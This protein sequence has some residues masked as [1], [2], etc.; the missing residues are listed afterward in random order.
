MD[1]YFMAKLNFY[2]TDALYK[3]EDSKAVIYLYG[4]CEQGSVLIKYSGFKPYFYVVP[5]NGKEKLLL[6]RLEGFSIT[7]EKRKINITKV[8]LK[9][10]IDGAKKTI[11]I[12][13]QTSIPKDVPHL[14][15]AIRELNN[16]SKVTEADIRFVNRFLVNHRIAIFEKCTAIGEFKGQVFLAKSITPGSEKYTDPRILAI[17]IETPSKEIN[18]EKYPIFMISLYGD[19]F[20]KV[21]TWKQQ[22]FN[23]KYVEVCTSEQKMLERFG[24]LVQEYNPDIICGYFS[25]EF[26]FPYIKRRADHLKVELKPGF[27]NSPILISRGKKRISSI[28]GMIHVDVFK[29]I[30]YVWGQGLNTSWFDLNSVA[31]EILGEGKIEVDIGQL[32]DSWE[33]NK[34]LD[35]FAEYNLKDSEL[36]YRL[37][38][39][40]IV[41]IIELC[42]LTHLTANQISRSRFSALVEGFLITKAYEDNVLVPKAPGHKKILERRAKKYQGAFVYEP[43]PGLYAN[44]AVFDFKS[45]YATL[46]SAFNI[47]PETLD[48]ECCPENKVPGL[49][50]WFCKNIRGFISEAEKEIVQR[51]MRLKE[52]ISKEGATKVLKARSHALKTLGNAMYGYIGFYASRWY[53][54]EA[55]EA[56]TAYGRDYLNQVIEKA[57][58]EGFEVVYGDTDS[59]FLKLPTKDTKKAKA[60]ARK[61]NESLPD[62]MELEFESFFP[63]GIFVSMKSSDVGAK[64]RYAMINEKGEITIKGFETVRRNISL[65]AREAQR[66][67]LELI[68]NEGDAK[69]ALEFIHKLVDQVK[70]NDI[71]KS[72]MIIKTQIKKA[73]SDYESVSPHVAVAKKLI[74]RGEKVNIGDR[75]EYVVLNGS[76]NVGDRAEPAQFVDNPDYDTDYY[77]N[78]QLIPAV[79]SIFQV[80]GMN[81][82]INS[83]DQSSLKTFF[84]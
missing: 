16:V 34:S 60:F 68:L 11:V 72:K 15:K 25:D 23:E 41:D 26:D 37:C 8:E 17:D 67:V 18:P 28:E 61:I 40:I 49:N 19:S 45:L 5:E 38:K 43:K 55:A 36:T 6:E 59:I 69:K 9:E 58:A 39:E 44:I 14:A 73:I 78:K 84:K 33:S 80:L 4:T 42:K 1:T 12:R 24:E 62:I 75:I 66:K 79:E 29:F 50:H 77:V 31:K 52:I 32:Q 47:S 21:L 64:K 20:K 57:K 22:S 51:R 13:C 74:S 83:K 3:I 63:R 81:D 46:I 82:I 54:F 2:P 71:P 76:G 27:N 30:R 7:E 70:A 53:S 35:L 56:I 48:C 10:K 65:L